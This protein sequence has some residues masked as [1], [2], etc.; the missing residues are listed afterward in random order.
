MTADGIDS[1]TGEL[2]PFFEGENDNLS[3]GEHGDLIGVSG[4][5]NS[6]MRLV[7]LLRLCILS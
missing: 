2:F 3:I 5:L 6:S 1:K 7:D 4:D